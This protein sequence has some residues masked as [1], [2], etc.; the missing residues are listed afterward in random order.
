MIYLLRMI[1]S[2]LRVLTQLMQ[3]FHITIEITIF[4]RIYILIQWT[5]LASRVGTEIF[6]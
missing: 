4:V 2:L 3:N 1:F 6:E 5:I